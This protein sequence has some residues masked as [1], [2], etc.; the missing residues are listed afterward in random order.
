MRGNLIF[1]RA[2]AMKKQALGVASVI[3]ISFLLSVT[4]HVVAFKLPD[5]MKDKDAQILYYGENPGR[6]GH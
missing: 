2:G 6:G 3:F 5:W 1:K 4:G